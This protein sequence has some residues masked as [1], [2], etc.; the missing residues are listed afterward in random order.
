MNQGS[1]GP[2]G[3]SGGNGAAHDDSRQ[4]VQ[5]FAREASAQMEHAKV[6]FDDINNRALAF[7]RE[8]PGMALLGAVA[9]G[10]V[11]GKIASKAK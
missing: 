5:E 1:S 8:R 10:Y 7:I 9:L 4:K 6:V 11:V 3:F 2:G